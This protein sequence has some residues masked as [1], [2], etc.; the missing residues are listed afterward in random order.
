MDW[1]KW[2][3]KKV[4]VKLKNGGYYSGKIIEIDFSLNPIIFITIIDKYGKNVSFVQSE[5]VKIVEEG[6]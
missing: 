4:F 1:K 3:N 6:E 5:I 2:E